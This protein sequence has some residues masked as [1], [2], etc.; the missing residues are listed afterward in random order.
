MKFVSNN[1]SKD[2]E[3]IID[4][5]ESGES[6]FFVRQD[7]KKF[8]VDREALNNKYATVLDCSDGSISIS[9]FN[10]DED[11]LDMFGNA[12]CYTDINMKIYV[13]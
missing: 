4:M 1:I 9:G 6:L 7:G 13:K 10:I 5:I 3:K 2:L 12:E 8:I 11:V